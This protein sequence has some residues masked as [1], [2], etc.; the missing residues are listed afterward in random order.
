MASE[1]MLYTG[2]V[3]GAVAAGV[4]GAFK[5]LIGRSMK[6]LDDK[7]DSQDKRLEEHENK[8]NDHD[9][10]HH[11]TSINMLKLRTYLSENYPTKNDLN[12]A[13]IEM[14]DSVDRLHTRIDETGG[15]IKTI[16]QQTNK[17]N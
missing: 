1:E 10:L 13:R 11:E 4:V 6:T 7:F 9:K 12:T 8:F 5:W 3:I 17:T 14:K 15:D 16:L 2:G